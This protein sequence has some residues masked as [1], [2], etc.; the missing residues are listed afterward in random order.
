MHEIEDFLGVRST[1]GPLFQFFDAFLDIMD[2]DVMVETP[3][4]P[5]IWVIFGILLYFRFISRSPC[6]L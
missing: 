4:L 1:R 5:H 2:D 6:E 3:F